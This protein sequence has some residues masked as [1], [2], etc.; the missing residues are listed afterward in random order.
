MDVLDSIDDTLAF[1]SAGLGEEISVPMERHDEGWV[2]LSHLGADVQA[3]PLADAVTVTLNTEPARFRAY[4]TRIRVVHLWT[5]IQVGDEAVRYVPYSALLPDEQEAIHA[6]LRLHGLDP[7]NV[8]LD[9]IL[10]FDSTTKEWRIRLYRTR[11]GRK[12]LVDKDEIA[13]CV[14]RRLSKAPLPWR[15]V[16]AAS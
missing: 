9:G 13:T 12:F 4:P 10:G 8:P 6:W 1:Y 5:Q 2:D 15:Q 7:S 3:D 11:G 16:E 14:V